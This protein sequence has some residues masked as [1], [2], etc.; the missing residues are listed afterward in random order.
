MKR[1]ITIK[2]IAKKL[3]CSVSTVSKALNNN[4]NVNEF[5]RQTIQE[6]AKEVGYQRNPIS[7]SLLNQKTYTI[8][9]IVPYI[10][11]TFYPITLDGIESVLNP[12]GYTI[13]I[14]QSKERM[15]TEAKLLNTMRHNRVDG[16]FLAPSIET[17]DMAHIETTVNHGI[18]LIIFDRDCPVTE[19]SKV[20]VDNYL[21]AY[22]AV[23]HLILTGCKRIAHLKG[24][25]NLSVTSDRLNGYLDALHH[26]NVPFED[27]LIVHA[28]FQAQ[29]GA[30]SVKTLLDLPLRPD[31]IFAVND[32]CAIGAMHI[33]REYGL[34][35][36]E[37]ISVIGV[38]DRPNSA[39]TWP[40]LTTISQPIYDM[41][42]EAAKL[43]LQQIESEEVDVVRHVTLPCKLVIRNSTKRTPRSITLNTSFPRPLH[44]STPRKISAGNER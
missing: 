29:A 39:Y 6:Y 2:D 11:D 25:D 5:T 15:D 14:S 18:P 42:E 19:I 24:P 1:Q 22:K 12:R 32:Y 28:G 38:D 34:R 43:L 21:G 40:T 33:I 16:I 17:T 9:V 4:P 8:G 13:S 23:E 10:T 26:Y 36:P 27:S 20:L 37:D 35:I 44:P 3:H 7:L 31:A 41:G 30:E